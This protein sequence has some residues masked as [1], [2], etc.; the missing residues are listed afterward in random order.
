MTESLFNAG[1]KAAI[2]NDDEVLILTKTEPWFS[3]YD[4]P[5]GRVQGN[6]SFEDC[7]TRELQEELPGITNVV[8]HNQLTTLN[9]G[10]TLRGGQGLLW[11]I[12]LVTATLPQ[13]IVLSEE[14]S[15]FEWQPLNEFL[16]KL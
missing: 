6:E 7:L 5:G 15:S 4:L 10:W 8:I 2:V 16:E 11:I 14:H 13:P 9:T 12:Y 1:I 3:E